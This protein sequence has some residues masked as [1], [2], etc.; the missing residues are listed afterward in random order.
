[1]S[2]R[3][4]DC[5]LLIEPAATGSWN[6]AVDEMLLE[7]VAAASHCTLRFYQ[8]SE[9]TLSLGYF[10]RY[11][12]RHSHAAS[13]DCPL[14]RRPTGGGA[15]V[16]DDEWTYSLVVPSS[17]R[18]V[19]RAEELYRAVHLALADALSEWKMEAVLRHE[20]DV[21]SANPEPF[22]CFERRAAGDLL[23]DGWKIA[24][25]AQRRRRGAL[26]QHGSAILRSSAAAPEVPGLDELG[27]DVDELGLIAGWRDCLGRRLGLTFFC[28][29][30]GD[31]E[32]ERAAEL[33][34][35]RYATDPWNKKR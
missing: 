26:L 30:L 14:V 28:E 34:R 32:E 1:M 31:R 9:A 27:C 22:L 2:A 24:G 17:S 15:I 4:F 25:S 6:M 12:E 11:E 7:S 21:R 18:L 23:V 20:E 29:S 35:E 19:S 16:H 10:Q 13:R 33:E 3:R 5:R 8:W